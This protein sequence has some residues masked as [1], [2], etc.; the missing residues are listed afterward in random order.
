MPADGSRPDPMTFGRQLV[1]GLGVNL[2]VRDVAKSIA[3][4][5]DILGVDCRYAEEHFAV[6]SYGPSLWQLHSDWSYR[7]HEM[8]QTLEGLD[9][10]GAGCELRLYGLDPDAVCA[11]AE[12]HD[13]T[14]LSAPVDKPHGLREAH[15][16]DSDGY[17]WVP[18]TALAA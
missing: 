7:D 9:F 4:Q 16:V 15:L 1:Q 14:I 3:F 11:R 8:R 12:Q 10:R 6:M 5:T 2:L 13:V 18:S 17:I